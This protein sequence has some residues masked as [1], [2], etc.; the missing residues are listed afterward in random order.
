[1]LYDPIY[2]ETLCQKNGNKIFYFDWL[3]DLYDNQNNKCILSKK[4][5]YYIPK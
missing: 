3:F 1:M 4:K 2:N 5:D